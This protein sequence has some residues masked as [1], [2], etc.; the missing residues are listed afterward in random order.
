MGADIKA[1]EEA[2]KGQPL[3]SKSGVR[4]AKISVQAE[5]K[6]L[7]CCPNQVRLSK[8][9]SSGLLSKPGDKTNAFWV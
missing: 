2:I 7:G 5:M 8:G 9:L 1:D 3:R 4:H 6:S